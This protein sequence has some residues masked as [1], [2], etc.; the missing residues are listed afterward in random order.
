M[1]IDYPKGSE[2]WQEWVRKWWDSM[3]II[4]KNSNPIDDSTGQNF[5]NFNQPEDDKDVWF[6]AGN[7]GGT[8]K[9]KIKVKKGKALFFPEVNFIG[10]KDPRMGDTQRFA[11]GSVEDSLYLKNNH[12]DPEK[13]AR[14][15]ITASEKSTKVD[16]EGPV[17]Q[18]I[19]KRVTLPF[20]T[21]KFGKPPVMGGADG[22]AECVSDGFWVF[23]EPLDAVGKTASIT[24]KSKH[25][26]IK[27]SDG[28][29]HSFDSTV[30]YEIDIIP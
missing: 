2:D 5:E 19:R 12:P 27:D 18:R 3:L 10:C 30:I 6:L 22:V 15:D 25:S 8:S 1:A 4:P 7:L 13:D 23:T 21:T 29:Q 20:W 24:I 11:F 16:Y 28:N 26:D 14:E 9:R 17:K